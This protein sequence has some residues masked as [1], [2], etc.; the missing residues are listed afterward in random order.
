M[1]DA[2]A[3]PTPTPAQR[4]GSVKRKSAAIR[5][6][7]IDWPSSI[8]PSLLL[9]LFLSFFPHLRE[10]K[11]SMKDRCVVVFLPSSTAREAKSPAIELAK[12]CKES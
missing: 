6:F 9:F 12:A 2:D 4:Q 5:G 10:K 1:G 3:S 11:T 8:V 7:W